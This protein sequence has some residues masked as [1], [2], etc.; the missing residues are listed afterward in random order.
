MDFYMYKSMCPRWYGW[1][2]NIRHIVVEKDTPENVVVYTAKNVSNSITGSNSCDVQLLQKY[3]MMNEAKKSYP[4]ITGLKFH[5]TKLSR[6]SESISLNDD[7]I[8]N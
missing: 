5:D 3:H 1:H 4:A 8:E 7:T 6:D 2:D